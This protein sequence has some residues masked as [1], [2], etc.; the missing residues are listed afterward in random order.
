MRVMLLLYG[1]AAPAVSSW[2]Q[3]LWVRESDAAGISRG[4]PAP[5]SIQFAQA[6]VP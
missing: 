4:Q 2:M 6:T 1:S 5:P 3:Q